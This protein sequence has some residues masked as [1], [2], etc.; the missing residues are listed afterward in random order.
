MSISS[1]YDSAFPHIHM[2]M[3]QPRHQDNGCTSAWLPI[4]HLTPLQTE[5][6]DRWVDMGTDRP[7]ALS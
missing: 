5:P 7:G 6:R 4:L 3:T 1:L 2:T